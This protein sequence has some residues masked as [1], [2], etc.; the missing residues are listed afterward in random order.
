MKMKKKNKPKTNNEHG[1]DEQSGSS[2]R[3]QSASPVQPPY[4]RR[5]CVSS[6]SA[7]ILP[8]FIGPETIQQPV[9]HAS[10]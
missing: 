5:T 3:A 7:N 4:L 10:V 9:G 2:D 8:L 1:A 6:V